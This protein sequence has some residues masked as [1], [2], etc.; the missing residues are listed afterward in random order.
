MRTIR[1]EFHVHTVLS[2]CAEIE[3]IPPL[4][5][6]EALS[7]GIQWIAITDHN[8]SANVEAVIQAAKG[9]GLIISP[10]MEVQTQEEIHSLC[11]FDTLEQMNAFQVFIDKSL[12]PIEN[13]PDYFGEQLVVD[14]TGDFIRIETRL[15]LNS[16]ALSIREAWEK[17]NE[18][19]GIL[20]PAHIDRKAFGMIANLGLIP[21]DTPIEALEISRHLSP[22]DA[23]STYPQIGQIPLIKSGDV[24]RLNEFLGV[25]QLHIETPSIAELRKA[26]FNMENRSLTIIER[27][28]NLK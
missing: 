23:R 9:T 3:M 2:P 19:G 8:A 10:G 5:V 12:P 27:S 11:L 13:R 28:E 6:E 24:H 21:I 26:L 15:L 20:I 16:A 4:I 14:E 17:V 7:K 22:T 1:A 18:L 25:N